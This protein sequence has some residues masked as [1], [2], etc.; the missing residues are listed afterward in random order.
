M[1]VLCIGHASFDITAPTPNYPEENTKN[2]IENCLYAGGGPAA[3]AAYLLGK[4]GIET[5]FVGMIGYDSYGNTIKQEFKSVNVDTSFLETDYENKTSTSFIVVNEKTGSRTVF[6]CANT[7]TQIKKFTFE[8]NPDIILIDGHQFEA[9]KF[10]LTRYPS[11]ISIIDAGRA[12]KEVM[13]LCKLIKYLVC[14]KEFAETV[15]GLKIDYENPSTLANVYFDLKEKYKNAEIIIT[16]ED[17]GSLYA[18]N[19]SVKL[20]P[21]IKKEVIKDTTG[22]GDIFH[23][24]FTY[25]I[26]SGYDLE[27]TMKI[28]NIAAG[29]SVERMGG[30][31]SIPDLNEV[32]DYYEKHQ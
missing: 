22:A 19:Q 5:I 6:N 2:R 20:L 25:S 32:I 12:T 30:R 13:E 3:N 23:G 11:A 15:T 29:L 31:L 9:S 27:K 16:L 18:F 10:A 17:R 28:S 14:S 26:A 1:K 4:W 21:A 24:A 7:H 8:I